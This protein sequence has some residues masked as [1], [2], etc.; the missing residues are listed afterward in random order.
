MQKEVFGVIFSLLLLYLLLP[1][2]FFFLFLLLV[3]KKEVLTG[4]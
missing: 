3:M 1:L 4:C 2:P